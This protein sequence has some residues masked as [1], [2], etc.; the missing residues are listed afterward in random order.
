MSDN[1][2]QAP[3]PANAVDK[4][5]EAK[6]TAVDFAEP[7]SDQNTGPAFDL[8]LTFV[9]ESGETHQWRKE[10]S[11]N[12]G[13][14]NNATKT[15]AQ[16]AFEALASIGYTTPDLSTIETALIGKIVPISVKWSYYEGK[17]RWYKNV[18]LG[19]GGLRK[20]EKAKALEIMRQ[21]TGG[22]PATLPSGVMASPSQP[23]PPPPQAFGSAPANPFG[24]RQ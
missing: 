7:I 19:G 10:V 21:L 20:M 16:I 9:D 2:Q 22:A 12:Y 4:N 3:R 6:I 14:G 1:T 17:N 18:Y 8:V 23:P 11:A 5:C 24:F 15:C 13:R